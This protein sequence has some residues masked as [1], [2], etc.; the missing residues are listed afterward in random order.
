MP[1]RCETR[2]TAFP[3]LA[4]PPVLHLLGFNAHQTCG[5]RSRTIEHGFRANANRRP[6]DEETPANFAAGIGAADCV[7]HGLKVLAKLIAA[8]PQ[9]FTGATVTVDSRI[10]PP[11]RRSRCYSA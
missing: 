1:A 8:H 2:S 5:E 10:T 3:T 9:R 7:S 11:R 4:S 6:L